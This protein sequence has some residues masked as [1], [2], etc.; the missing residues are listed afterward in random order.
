MKLGDKLTDEQFQLL[1]E[2]MEY[3]R[4]I[5]DQKVSIQNNKTEDYDNK[6]YQSN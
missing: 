5:N 6:Q 3:H 1:V 2:E 4:M